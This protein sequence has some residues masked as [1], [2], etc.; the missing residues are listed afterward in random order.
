MIESPNSTLI[1]KGFGCV[2]IK[3]EGDEE[4]EMGGEGAREGRCE[5]E[6]WGR[7]EGGGAG[8]RK[9]R[10]GRTE[11]R[12]SAAPGRGRARP[13]PRRPPPSAGSRS[14]RSPRSAVRPPG[15]RPLPSSSSH[16]RAEAGLGCWFLLV[17][18]PDR[19]GGAACGP[20]LP[21]LESVGSVLH[22]EV[23][24]LVHPHS[25]QGVIMDVM[26]QRTKQGSRVV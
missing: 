13:A 8:E 5:Q 12:G 9:Q 25:R 18:K 2:A 16:P 19:G 22:F 1:G 3:C 11:P 23:I 10:K 6:R 20:P 15:S 14:L 21:P 7:E 24:V 4:M 26:S 17:L